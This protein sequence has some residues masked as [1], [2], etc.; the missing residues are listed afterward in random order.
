[1]FSDLK[2]A[3][4]GAGQIAEAHL[5]CL[6]G[7]PDVE[8]VGIANRSGKGLTDLVSRYNIHDGFNDWKKM[9][10]NTTPDAVWIIPS[11]L[12]LHDVTKDVIS[13]G[14]DCFIEKPVA[15]N[16]SDIKLLAELAD[17]KNTKVMVGFNRRFYNPIMQSWLL[18][19][20]A[21]ELRSIHIEVNEDIQ[22]VRQKNKHPENI[23]DNWMIANS[24]HLIDLITLFC[25]D[26]SVT[27][28]LHSNTKNLDEL[29]FHAQLSVNHKTAIGSVHGDWASPR[30]SNIKIR[31]D[32]MLINFNGLN[33]A[34][35]V[36]ANTPSVQIFSS[37]LDKT[38][39]MGFIKQ[40]EYF[41]NALMNGTNIGKPAANLW[42]CYRSVQLAETIQNTKYKV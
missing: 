4:I 2:I 13:M 36:S 27:N 39:K 31:L 10:R 19:K 12:S 23:I 7:H 21:G 18:S 15:L 35:I 41:I 37:A 11:I 5:Q 40:T 17:K 32:D 38:H 28:L 30:A 16:S 33:V 20:S 22:K 6:Q 9:L 34:E 14:Y 42:D 25:D 29:S 26:F 8:I 3:V 24:I 1:M